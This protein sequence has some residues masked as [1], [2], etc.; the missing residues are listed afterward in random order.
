[1]DQK[2]IEITAA[3]ALERLMKF[4]VSQRNRDDHR[5]LEACNILASPC[6]RFNAMFYVATHFIVAFEKSHFN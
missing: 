5:M 1:M 3:G 2:L 6:F 4:P